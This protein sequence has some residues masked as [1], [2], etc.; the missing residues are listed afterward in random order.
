M[1]RTIAALLFLVAGAAAAGDYRSIAEP[2]VLYDAPSL[3]ATK[4]YVIGR[5]VPVELIASDGTW[6]KVRDVSGELAWI[7]KKALS[8]NRTVVVTAPVAD[9]REKADDQAPLAFRAQQGVLL[10]LLDMDLIGWVHVRH[11]DGATGYVRLSEVW[12]F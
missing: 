7:D 12:G 9:V 1:S 2:A 10:E 11:R 3:R 6:V 5:Q 4:L 8:E